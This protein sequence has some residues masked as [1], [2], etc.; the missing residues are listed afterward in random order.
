MDLPNATKEIERSSIEAFVPFAQNIQGFV[1]PSKVDMHYFRTQTV[2]KSHKSLV[3]WKAHME[4][5]EAQ[6]PERSER[7]YLVVSDLRLK[8]SSQGYSSSRGDQARKAMND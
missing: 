2:Q 6:F 5:I 3:K 7:V 1:D 8:M 4:D